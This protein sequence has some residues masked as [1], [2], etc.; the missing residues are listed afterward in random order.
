MRNFIFLLFILIGVSAYAKTNIEETKKAIVAKYDAIEIKD[1]EEA[2]IDEIKALYNQS[3]EINFDQGIIRGLIIL[4]RTAL[5]QNDY[6]LAGNYGS[7]AEKVAI[8]INDY[9]A[10]S[11]I[12]VIKGQINSILDKYPEAKADLETS[13]SFSDKITNL[14][15]RYIQ[16]STIY[17]NLAGMSEGEN[18]DGAIYSYLQKAYEVIEKVPTQNLTEIQKSNY[19]NLYATA[20]MNLGSYNVYL[21]KPD[22]KTAELYFN[23]M[24]E[25]QKENPKYTQ[26]LEI[27][28]YDKLSRVYLKKK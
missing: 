24:L 20:L 23:K 28:I 13:L 2:R 22:L 9:G 18:K 19:Y 12:Y 7:E 21:E 10:L 16:Q 14:A 11:G 15:D 3:R 4:Q 17:A 1:E 27:D 8:K 5:V 6:I 25:F 26:S